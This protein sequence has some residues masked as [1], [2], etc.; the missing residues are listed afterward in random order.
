MIKLGSVFSFEWRVCYA[1]TD[2]GGVVYHTR[3]L[4]F[5]ERARSAMLVEL[6]LSNHILLEQD[7]VFTVKKVEIVYNKP[8]KLDD[9]VSI[10]TTVEQ[11]KGASLLLQQHITCK[12]AA[13]TLLCEMHVLL[14][15]VDRHGKV[16]R[17]PKNAV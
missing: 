6:G 12:N 7:I 4:E 17:L 9:I 1:D 16:R 10:I 2:A 3:Y 11:V 13:N 8:A 14:A 15:C 5:A